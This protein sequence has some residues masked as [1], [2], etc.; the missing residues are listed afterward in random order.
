MTTKQQRIERME[1]E[2][3]ALKA[4]VEAES[5]PEPQVGEVRRAPTGGFHCQS[6]SDGVWR[7]IT[8][9]GCGNPLPAQRACADYP[10]IGQMADILAHWKATKGR[11]TIT[12]KVGD[13]R[14]DIS[15]NSV[16]KMRNGELVVV[17]HSDHHQWRCW[18][19]ANGPAVLA[20][21]RRNFRGEEGPDYELVEYI[22]QLEDL[23]AIALGGQK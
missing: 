10:I 1:A 9:C 6:G 17:H 13:D 7:Y 14:P 8:H 11:P 19:P 5:H 15:H 2:L 18:R 4:E 12:P 23:V 20:N 22:G 21:H 16:W 3:A